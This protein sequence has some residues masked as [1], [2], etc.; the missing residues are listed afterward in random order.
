[1]KIREK[2][3]LIFPLFVYFLKKHT[4]NYHN[5]H[6]LQQNDINTKH[7]TYRAVK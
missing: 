7:Y 1:M 2:N 6:K 3:D 5:R 4:I